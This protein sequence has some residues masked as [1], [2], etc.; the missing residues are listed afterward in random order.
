MHFCRTVVPV[1][2]PSCSDVIYCS[3]QCQQRSSA[4]YHRFECGILPV[5]WRSGASINNHMALRIMASKPLDYFLQLRS[6][7]D[8]QLSLEQLLG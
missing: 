5:I 4:K 8:E 6:S 1:A 2:C 7:L 3:E